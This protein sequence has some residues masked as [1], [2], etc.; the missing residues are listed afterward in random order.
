MWNHVAAAE[1]RPVGAVRRRPVQLDV[2]HLLVAQRQ[3]EAVAEGQQ[4]LLGHLLLLVGDVLTLARLA[5]PVALDGLG[6]DHGRRALVFDGRFVRRVNLLR[7]V[8]A[9]R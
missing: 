8:S 4:R 1:V 7:I 5:H 6:E 3:P 2:P 9:T